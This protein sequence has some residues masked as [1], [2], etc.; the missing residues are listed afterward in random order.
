M[1]TTFHNV[2]ITIS[3]KTPEDAYYKLCE[4]LQ[5]NGVEFTTST[6]TTDQPGGDE[7]SD[8]ANLFG[9]FDMPKDLDDL[10]F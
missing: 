7:D 6:Y 4:M 9:D 8:T 3:A 2:L 5:S 1:E 10:P